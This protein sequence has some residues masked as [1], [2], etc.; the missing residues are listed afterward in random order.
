MMGQ[1][2]EESDSVFEEPNQKKIHDAYNVM[3]TFI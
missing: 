1:K 2:K 3:S